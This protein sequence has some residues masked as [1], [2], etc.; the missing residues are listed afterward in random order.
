M[1][2]TVKLFNPNDGVT[3]RPAGTYLDLELAKQR[4]ARSAKLEG[5]KPDYD[6]VQSVGIPLHTEAE[7][8]DRHYVP[9][10]DIQSGKVSDKE[11]KHF[12]DN[13]IAEVKAPEAKGFKTSSA[14]EEAEFLKQGEKNR[15]EQGNNTKK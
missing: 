6:I 8:K 2:E 12:K 3:G 4:E 9:E 14:K 13:A 1:S 11:A 10:V 15:T 5:R 7:L